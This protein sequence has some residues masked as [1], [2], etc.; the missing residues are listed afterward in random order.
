M[1]DSLG[2]RLLGQ[3]HL[4]QPC[5]AGVGSKDGIRD[6]SEQRNQAEAE[7]QR[8]IEYHPRPQSGWQAAVNF[9]T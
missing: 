8:D 5:I 6:I 2:F 1:T 3:I 7:V 9:L 4:Q